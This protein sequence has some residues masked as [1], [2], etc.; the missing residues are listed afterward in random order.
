[1]IP[2]FMRAS[3]VTAGAKASRGASVRRQDDVV[4]TRARQSVRPDT[5]P[6]VVLVARA[7]PHEDAMTITS[8]LAGL[9]LVALP[10]SVAA[11]CVTPEPL[12]RLKSMAT[13]AVW[14]AGRSV[15]TQEK[16][17]V[18]VA[19]AFDHQDAGRIAFRVE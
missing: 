16:G 13:D 15:E 9:F 6:R 3:W 18:R 4:V 8:R 14:I 10:L 17:G 5:Q 11:G 19:A 2:I 12:V 7:L 1:M